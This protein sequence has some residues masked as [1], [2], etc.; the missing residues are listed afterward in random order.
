[1]TE[2]I[3]QEVGKMLKA[4][5]FAKEGTVNFISSDFEV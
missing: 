3:K 5:Q 4:A 2:V 1:M